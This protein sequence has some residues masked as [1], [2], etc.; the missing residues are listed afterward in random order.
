MQ[1]FDKEY[2]FG[3]HDGDCSGIVDTPIGKSTSLGLKDKLFVGYTYY[4]SEQIEELVEEFGE[5]WKGN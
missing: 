3:G 2:Y 5:L 1:V 4:N